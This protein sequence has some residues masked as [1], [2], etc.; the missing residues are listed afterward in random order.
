MHKN[1]EGDKPGPLTPSE[2]KMFPLY[3]MLHKRIWQKQGRT[4]EVMVFVF[5]S[6]GYISQSSA[7]LGM[8]GCGKQ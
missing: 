2:Q 3:G 1:L 4:F 5:S 7:F 6:G 8:A